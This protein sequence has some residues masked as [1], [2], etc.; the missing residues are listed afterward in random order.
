MAVQKDSINRPR[1]RMAD[2]ELEL[3]PKQRLD[4]TVPAEVT[5]VCISQCGNFGVVGSAAG[6]VDRYNMQSGLHRSQFLRVNGDNSG[7][8]LQWPRLTLLRLVCH[9]G[10]RTQYARRTLASLAL[11]DTVPVCVWLV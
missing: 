11:G 6:R 10:I 4:G 8:M 9:I 2:Q 7:A 3:P 5:A 1:C